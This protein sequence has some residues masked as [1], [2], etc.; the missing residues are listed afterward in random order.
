M[1]Q[2]VIFDMD[3]LMF[4]TERLAYTGYQK[5]SGEMG[6]PLSIDLFKQM[7]GLSFSNCQKVFEKWFN[8][9]FDFLQAEKICATYVNSYLATQPVPLKKGL[10]ELLIYL[11]DN[12]LPAAIATSTPRHSAFKLWE[13]SGVYGYIQQTV[14]GD[15]VQKGKPDPEIFLTAARKLNKDPKECLILEDSY[16]G[17]RAAHAAGAAACMVPDMC[18]PIPEIAQ[19]CS[20]ICNDLLQV[21]D[22]LDL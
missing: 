11:S 22:I 10:M 20:Y 15:E 18:E 1:I 8:G 7:C 13:S 19:L 12:S 21:I 14:C 6:F 4:D 2:A 17:I 5:A 3:G 16:N 9:R